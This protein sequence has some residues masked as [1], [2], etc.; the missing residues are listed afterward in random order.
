MA[1]QTAQAPYLPSP[2]MLLNSALAST[3][4]ALEA[5]VSMHSAL[6]SQPQQAQPQQAQPQQAQPQQAQPQQAQPQQAQPQQAQPQQAQLLQQSAS[7]LLGMLNHHQQVMHFPPQP[8]QA[9]DWSLGQAAQ[10]P[11]RPVRPQH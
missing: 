5:V 1:V 4:S 2:L 11:L 10:P 3:P 8:K 9:Q 6:G 7:L